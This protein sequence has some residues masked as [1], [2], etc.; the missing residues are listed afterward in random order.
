V[1]KGSNR[2]NANE[3]PV[4][5]LFSLAL[6]SKI[7]AQS[8]FYSAI[9]TGFI[10]WHKNPQSDSP[11]GASQFVGESYL[12]IASDNPNKYKH[13]LQRDGGLSY[14]QGKSDTPA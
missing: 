4:S 3:S 7:Q 8:R 1:K 6:L 11:K 12:D 13:T 5:H 14:R 2:N 10:Q 9:L